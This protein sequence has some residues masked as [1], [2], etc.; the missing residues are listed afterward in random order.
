MRVL[1]VSTWFPYPPSTG[2]KSRAHHLLRVLGERHEVALISFADTP[3]EPEWIDRVR[4]LCG[5]VEVV[6]R[7]PFHQDRLRGI[8][9][10]LS[11]RPRAVVATDSSEMRARVAR[12]ADAWR[13]THVMALTAATAPYVLDLPA[14]LRPRASLDVDN[15]MTRAL[16]D[17]YRRAAGPRRLRRWAAWRKFQRYERRLIRRFDVALLL[18]QDDVDIVRPFVAGRGV[19]LAI[20]PNGV[21]VAHHR[22][23]LVE[24]DR[25]RLVFNGS[26]TYEPNR[27]AMEFFVA[28]VLP[29]IRARV[30][31][32]RLVITGA[33]EPSFLDGRPPPP[34][35]ELTGHLADVR[36]AVAGSWACVVP[37]RLGGGTRV[38]I[39]EAMAL[40]TPVVSTRKGAEGLEVRDGV[41]LLLADSAAEL[42]AQTLRLIESPA[43]RARLAADARRLVEERYDW[44]AIGTRL[45]RV[46]ERA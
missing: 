45:C 35:V 13:P 28:E 41:H 7:P 38:K 22:P 3:I 46:I 44:R 10:F 1:V 31:E 11:P 43:L 21:D 26:L 39:L 40:G 37:L 25:H 24:P 2:A 23:G 33:R 12:L 8:L 14:R 4:R 29:T 16:Y 32:L 9:G 19:R 18:S 17:E 20:V 34:G 6:E 27:D 5:H 42:A 30:P 36:P 15:L